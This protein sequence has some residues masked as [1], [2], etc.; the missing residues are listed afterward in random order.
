[1]DEF[2]KLLDPGLDY[3][4]HELLDDTIIIRVAS[5]I[6]KFLWYVGANLPHIKG[7]SDDLYS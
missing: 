5:N 4:E 6:K 2:I 7:A 3:I 1:M